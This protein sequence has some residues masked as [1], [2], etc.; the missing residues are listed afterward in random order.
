[1]FYPLNYGERIVLTGWNE[2]LL[3]LASALS[4]GRFRLFCFVLSEAP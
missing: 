4:R 3:L 1:L 2:A